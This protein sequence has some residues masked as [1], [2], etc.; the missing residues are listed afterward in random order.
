[1]R[2]MK[3][4]KVLKHNTL[5]QEVRVIKPVSARK[6]S[7]TARNALWLFENQSRRVF[8]FGKK[9]IAL[10]RLY[11]LCLKPEA[12]SKKPRHHNP[13]DSCFFESFKMLFPF[14]AQ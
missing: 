7:K 12:G 14:T 5:V 13:V 2:V 1:M 3:A 9:K 11:D 6:Y 10:W 4:R 8:C